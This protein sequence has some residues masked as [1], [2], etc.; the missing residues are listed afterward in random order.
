MPGT[1]QVPCR[2]LEV[3]G[4]PGTYKKMTAR[5]TQPG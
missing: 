2:A 1:L 3:P 5:R 4:K